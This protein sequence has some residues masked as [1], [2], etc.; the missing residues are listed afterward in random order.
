MLSYSKKISLLLLAVF[1][2]TAIKG[3][4]FAQASLWNTVRAWVT[5]NPLGVEVSAPAK[6][7]LNEVFKVEA[8]II[9]K[10]KEK[11]ENVKGEIHLPA[12]LVL[13]KKSPVQRIGA[14]PGGKAK[15]I[16]WRVKGQEKGSYI[17]VVSASGELMRE[18]ISAEGSK[19]IEVKEEGTGK[20]PP[21]RGYRSGVFKRFFGFFQKWFGD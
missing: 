8:K 4:Y 14:L 10:G 18:L 5:I 21:G 13:L 12:G 3:N 7:A 15:E 19:T 20:I 11:V 16:S 1:I 2:L 17:I 9:N 6:V